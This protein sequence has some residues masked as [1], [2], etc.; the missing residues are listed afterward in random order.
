MSAEA[1]YALLGA[2]IGVAASIITA[3]I[4]KRHEGSKARDQRE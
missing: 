2:G 3:L 1:G 4:T